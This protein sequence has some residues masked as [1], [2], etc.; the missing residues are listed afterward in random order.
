M[1]QTQQHVTIDEGVVRTRTQLTYKISRA[2]LTGLTIETPADHRV[3]NVFDPNVREWT[4]EP[5]EGRNRIRIQLYQPARETQQVTVELEKFSDDLPREGIQVPMV[6]AMDVGRQQGI[7]VVGVSEALRAEVTGRSGL[8]QLDA[9]ELPAA[10]A[11]AKPDFS[12]R[13]ASLPF[14]LSL[15]VEQV[16]P[17]I[18]TR[19]LVEAY[20]EPERLTLNL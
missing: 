20:L 7:V 11:D 19:E 17:E 16:Q 13:Y 8:F 5:Q 1:V 2:E 9:S 6:Q 10:L 18:R 4:V 12:Y 3:L 14:E 15:A